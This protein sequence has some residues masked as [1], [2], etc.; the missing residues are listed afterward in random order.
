MSHAENGLASH[1]APHD[2]QERLDSN[3][4]DYRRRSPLVGP[5]LG[6]AIP[7]M[8]LQFGQP[9]I[10]VLTA[11]WDRMK[12]RAISG[13]DIPAGRT[14]FSLSTRLIV[15]ARFSGPK[16]PARQSSF[17]KRVSSVILPP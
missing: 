3:S 12:R 15:W 14:S 16:Y 1:S 17:G 11:V 13:S 8:F 4:S 6:R 9:A 5:G 2:W 10:V 7:A